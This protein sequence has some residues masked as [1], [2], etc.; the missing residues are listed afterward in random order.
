[1]YYNYRIEN[2]ANEEPAAILFTSATRKHTQTP[3][4]CRTEEVLVRLEKKG[5]EACVTEGSITFKHL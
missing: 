3:N 2:R 4:A 1:M 5:S